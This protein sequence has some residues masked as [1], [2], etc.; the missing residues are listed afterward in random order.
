MH[1]VEEE[2]FPEDD[3]EWATLSG[4]QNL[5]LRRLEYQEKD[6]THNARSCTAETAEIFFHIG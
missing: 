2:V 4:E 3:L 1:L 5:E 6:K